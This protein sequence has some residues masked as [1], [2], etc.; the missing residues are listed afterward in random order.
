MP[1]S[2]HK[3]NREK[4]LLLPLV[5]INHDLMCRMLNWYKPIN[6]WRRTYKDNLFGAKGRIVSTQKI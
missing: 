1:L 4:K 2:P 3:K 5:K 6:V